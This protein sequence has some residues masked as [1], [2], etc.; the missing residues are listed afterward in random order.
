VNSKTPSESFSQGAIVLATFSRSKLLKECLKSIYSDPDARL[1]HKVIVLQTGSLEVEKIVGKYSDEKTI[2]V[3]VDGT[4]KSPLANI[5][6]N[7]WKGLQV[8]FDVIGVDWVLELEDDAIISK[9]TIKFIRYAFGKY[10][11]SYL[12]RGVNLGSLEIAKEKGGYSLLRSSFHADSGMMTKLSWKII[13]LMR[14][15]NRLMNTPLDWNIEPFW[16]TGFVVTPNNSKCM[17]YGWINGTHVEA[18]PNQEHFRKL[19][20]S[21]KLKDWTPPY[22]HKQ[23]QHSWPNADKEFALSQEPKYIIQFMFSIISHSYFYR[24]TYKKMRNFKRYI[25]NRDQI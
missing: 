1:C 2:V 16:K 19:D 10:G 9:D 6:S 11:S 22:S 5:T 21:W 13:K 17:N 25:M 24:S 20:R 18:N 4:G 23:I 8:A 15:K 14:I 3:R 7:Y 12:F